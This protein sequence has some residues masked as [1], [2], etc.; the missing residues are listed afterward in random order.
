[1]RSLARSPQHRDTASVDLWEVVTAAAIS[2]AEPF[3]NLLGINEKLAAFSVTTAGVE[4]AFTFAQLAHE[5]RR[6]WMTDSLA[7]NEL[8]IL[9]DC[10]DPGEWPT[11]L[12][13]ARKVWTQCRF[14]IPRASGPGRKPRKDHGIKRQSEPAPDTE[15]GFIHKR[16]LLVSEA[17]A[18]NPDLM[19]GVRSSRALSRASVAEWSVGQDEGL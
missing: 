15:A 6:S 2:P 12:D 17:K 7:E 3:Q 8:K 5:A 14:G 18:R 16:R 19:H 13:I 4:Q 9:A 10:R 11:L 1:M